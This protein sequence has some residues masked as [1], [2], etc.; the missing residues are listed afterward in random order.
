M[1]LKEWSFREVLFSSD[2]NDNFNQLQQEVETNT[3]RIEA[4]ETPSVETLVGVE[5][6]IF[7]ATWKKYTLDFATS[8][9]AIVTIDGPTIFEGVN[10]TPGRSKTVR[11]ESVS[12]S[13]SSLTFPNWVF[14]GVKPTQMPAGVVVV[15]STGR[16]LRTPV[17][18]LTVT[19]MGTGQ[20]NGVAAWA[21]ET[22]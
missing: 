1:V 6:V 7:G 8:P 17:G 20:L 22:S 16:T 15:G 5:E 13:V 18:L 2:L 19:C 12:D 3:N 9:L 21:I 14:V 10:Y 4:L 11:V